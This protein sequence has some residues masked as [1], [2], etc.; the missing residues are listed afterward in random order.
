M[1]LGQRRDLLFI[2]LT[3]IFVTN[4]LLA[5][6]IGGKLIQVA[7]FV[8]SLGVIQ[9]PVVFITTDLVNEYFGIRGVRRLTFMTVG[10]IAYA[11]ITLFACMQIPAWENSPVKDEAFNM[12]FGQ[13]MWIIVGSIVAFVVSQLIDVGVF[14]LFRAK[15]AGKHLWLRSTGSTVFSQLIDTFIVMG[16]GFYLPGKLGLVDYVSASSNNYIYKLAIAVSMTPIIYL[17][18][19]GIDL[20]LGKGESHRLIEDAVANSIGAAHVHDDDKIEARERRGGTKKLLGAT[21][22]KLFGT[23]KRS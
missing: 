7:G 9:W 5:E 15:T 11:F 6:L 18:H 1:I 16:I 17:A 13:S 23:K 14:W 12:V 19:W 3:G 22:K 21:K 20:F 2:V 10:L 8:M 4:A